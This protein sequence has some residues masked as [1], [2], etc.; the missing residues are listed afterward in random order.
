MFKGPL[1][2]IAF[3]L[4]LF[5]ANQITALTW[6]MGGQVVLHDFL[7]LDIPGWLHCATIRIIA[8]I[9]AL[10]CV[11]SSGAE[12]MYQLL[13][14]TQVLMALLLPSS[15]IPLFRIAASRQIMGV[16]KISQIVEF[17]TLITFIGMLVL[18][19]AFV[20]EMVFGNSDWV[21]NLW[22]VGSSLSASYVVLVI[23]VCS[24]FCL[25]LW[26]AATPLKSASVPLDAQAWNW[27]S[28]KSVPDSFTNK[29]DIDITKSRYHNEAPVLKQEPPPVI[30]K[31]SESQSDVT[32]EDFDFGLPETIMEPDQEYQLTTVEETSSSHAFSRSSTGSTCLTEEST[33]I[34]ET[35]P[36]STVVGEVS[37]T[38]LVSQSTLRT[39][40]KGPVEK[41]LGV[42]PDLQVEKDDDEVDTWE[43]DDLSKVV[44][45]T[46]TLTSEGPG[47]FRSLSGKSD[48]GGNG[49]GSLSRLAGLGRAARRQLAAVLDE[50]W[51][52]LYDFHGQATQEARAKKLDVLFGAD[53]R[54]VSSSLNVDTTAKDSPVYFPAVGARGS[55]PLTNSSLYDSPKQHRVQGN[56]ES[57]YGV[58]RGSS[59]LWSSNHMQLLDAY[60]QSSNRNVVDSGERRYSSVRN[61]PS[62][63]GWGDYQPATVHGYQFASYINRVS[64]ERN[65]ENLNGQLQSP[66]MKSSTL[67]ATANYRDSLAYAMGQKLQNGLSSA[68]VSSIQ[69]LLASRNSMMQTERP[70]YALCPSGTAENLVNSANTKK[71]H[72]LPDIHRDIYA[73]DRNPQW[74]GPSG[75][76]SSVSRTSYEQPLYSNSGSRAGAPLAFDEL[77]PS[78]VY[79]DALSSPMTTSFDAGSLWSRQPFEQFGLADTNRAVD[80]GVGSRTSTV[81]HEI[82]SS[83]D[84][85]A[86]LL[87]SFRHCIVKLLKLE[88][89]DWLFRQNDGADEELIDRVA[90]RE[91]FLYEA[92]ARELNRVSPT[93]EPQYVSPD[94]KYSSL[95]NT[96][97]S[98]S[99]SMVYSVPHCGEGCVWKSDLIVSFGVWCIH[100]VL[101]LSLMESRPEL[102]GKYTYV[103]NRLQVNIL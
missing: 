77:S 33:I 6:G 31:P 78:K 56:L 71:Y 72:S 74:E 69:S 44:P 34:A 25:M 48:D 62:S 53:L 8:I 22:D 70:Y 40:T 18:K 65:A 89:S 79:R 60:V 9:P 17:L 103:L 66:V 41:T 1:A 10:Y 42:E 16:Y 102:W 86:K 32:V 75:F 29:E 57:T 54:A 83:P 37:D 98:F 94:R 73:S 46:P 52:Q 76:G 38:V 97:A 5:V 47:S 28:P 12:G 96:D 80:S 58:Q 82:T 11:W 39:D 3:L 36:I 23:I 7:K 24:S 59:A 85:E 26:L 84:S 64:K 14:F 13:I 50:F 2:P 91:K 4:V 15:V 61:L 68:Q 45:G 27:D 87:Q 51:G 92:E 20:V 21:G 35:V 81:N 63:E 19:I 101:D 88:G 49:A 95:R 100:R 30:V 67:G 93:G 43:A 55:D 99:H 90:A